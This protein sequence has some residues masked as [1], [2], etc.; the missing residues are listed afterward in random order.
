MNFVCR[1]ENEITIDWVEMTDTVYFFTDN[2]Y[3]AMI[4]SCNGG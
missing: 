3:A 1:N 4:K 2:I